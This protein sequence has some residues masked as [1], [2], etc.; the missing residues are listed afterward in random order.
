METVYLVPS[1]IS[2]KDIGNSLK[3]K[4]NPYRALWKTEGVG[5]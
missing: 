1:N 3:N 2:V 5:G 4:V